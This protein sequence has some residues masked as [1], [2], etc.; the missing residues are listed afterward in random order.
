MRVDTGTANTLMRPPPAVALVA[1]TLSIS[2]A[3]LPVFLLGALAV[4]VRQDLGFGE[5]ALGLVVSAYYLT[6]A[7]SSAPGGRLAE[8]LGARRGIALAAAITVLS[9]FGVALFAHTW[10]SLVPFMMLA[11]VA[12]GIAL[13]ASNLLLARAVPSRHQGVAFGVKQ[14]SG[15]V[16][17][18]ISGAAVPLIGLTVGWRWAFVLIALVGMP[19]LLFARAQTQNPLHPPPEDG[20]V[21]MGPLVL[22]G[23]GAAAAVI[24]GS[25]LGAFYVES[26]VAGGIAPGVAGTLLA[27]GAVT[28]IVARIG[29]GWFAGT[30]HSKHVT[31]LTALLAAG[32]GGYLFLGMVDTPF[33]LGVVSVVLFATGW[34]WPAVF[35]YAIVARTERAPAA[36]TGIVGA[37]LYAGGIFGPVVFGAMVESGGY[38]G[39][40]TFVAVASLVAAGFFFVGGRRLDAT[41]RENSISV[42]GP[43]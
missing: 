38:R 40:W 25:T 21:P 23:I 37:G 1:G 27:I 8:R 29:W 35:L 5:S 42:G 36:A 4:F 39:A 18:M 11:G 6:S 13:P 32:S 2:I 31:L 16:A 19:L 41:H 24:G 43:T 20:V 34:G 30:N 10:G 7:L 17:T 22:L 26:A 14:S 3:A 9:L 33:L 15:P 12:N 28:G